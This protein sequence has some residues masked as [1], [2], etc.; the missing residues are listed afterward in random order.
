M[1]AWA[2]LWSSLARPPPSSAWETL[3]TADPEVSP[4]AYA[5]WNVL[6]AIRSNT[7][8]TAYLDYQFLPNEVA[9]NQYAYLATMEVA[10]IAPIV[11]AARAAVAALPQDHPELWRAA[12][13]FSVAIMAQMTYGVCANEA[14]A[15]HLSSKIAKWSTQWQLDSEGRLPGAP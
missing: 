5:T 9:G 2:T 10:I 13:A 8:K 4:L 11:K 1:T 15:H 7:V 14:A 6:S 3:I 12:A